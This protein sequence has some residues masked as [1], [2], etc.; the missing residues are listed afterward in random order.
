MLLAAPVGLRRT[1]VR[2]TVSRMTEPDHVSTTRA[3][4]D[5]TAAEYAAHIGTEITAAIEAPL[6]RG[7]LL[8]F[9]EMVDGGGTVMDV[10]CGPGRVAAF[11]AARG[12][13]VVGVDASSGMLAVA[14][15]AHPGIGF[16]QGELA[17]L[18]VTDGALAGAVS[19]YSIIHTPAEHL[20]A[21]AAELVRALAPGGH[22]LVAFQ[23]GDGERSH[24]TEIQG[25]VVSLTSHR[26]GIDVVAGHL[27]DAG[28][29]VHARVVREPE[30]A[31][32]AGPQAFLLAR[33][34]G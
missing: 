26:H 34:A 6:D 24:R 1:G 12:L 9:A 22:A 19:W 27:A 29:R 13:D 33:A 16:E 15:D 32:E 8:A 25:K 18:P 7:V 2:R 31:H 10:G 17:A 4:Y 3:A 20:G 28:L 23:S 21:V 30:L 5:A 14:R 11:L